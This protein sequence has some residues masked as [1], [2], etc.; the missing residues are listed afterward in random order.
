MSPHDFS[1]RAFL[2]NSAS[3]LAAAGTPFY[4]TPGGKTVLVEAEAFDSYGGWS[5]DSQFMDVMGSPYLMAHGLGEPVAD[6]VTTVHIP[7]PGTYRVY[8]RTVNWAAK[9]DV[10]GAP[11][12]FQVAVNGQ[13]LDHVFGK[14]GAAW[15]WRE[16]GRVRL[17]A[18]PA[19]LRLVDLTGFN[20]RCDALVLTSDPGFVPP[21]S[22]DELERFRQEA[23]G[24]PETPELMDGYDLVVVGG[25]MAGSSA[26][27]TAARLGL[28]VALIQDRPVQ[29]GNNS[30][31]IRV[32]MR[33]GVHWPP[34]RALGG[35]VYEL[36]PEDFAPDVHKRALTEAEPHLDLFLDTRMVR[37]ETEGK[38]IIAIVTQNVRTARQ[39][40]FVGRCFADCT[41]DGN[42]GF[43]AGADYR[44]GRES[45]SQTGETGAPVA[46]D[47]QVMGATLK[48][49]S[50]ETRS[51][52]GF[53]DTPWA[54]QFNEESHQPA[55]RG[56][57]NWEAGFYW[58]Q[59]DE[60][61]KIRDHL[62]RAIFG[63]WSY[64]KNR[65]PD[66]AKYANYRLKWAAHILGKRESRRLLGDVILQE[67]DIVARREF[68]DA[69]VTTTWSIDV[70]YP[71]PANA[72]H[73]SKTEAF[74][75]ESRFFHDIDPYPVPYRCLYSRNIE[76]LF[77]AGRCLSVSHEALGTIR[78]MN[79]LGM[80]GVV[81][82]RAAAVAC[83]H[84][85]TNRR[86]C[87][88][89]WLSQVIIEPNRALRGTDYC[90]TPSFVIWRSSPVRLA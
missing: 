4:T 77:M 53:P 42:L 18:G 51:P 26:A 49:E 66:K 7:E 29:G 76:N 37:A 78:V 32:P 64:Q 2:K 89:E 17:P 24:L 50:E 28:S 70:H 9:F 90:T 19:E 30:S 43:A 68:P 41:G 38:R 6:A 72:A 52:S 80:V 47:N 16:G 45:L 54:V 34:Y 1:R 5:R 48:W 36:G 31:E 84:N 39:A 55:L 71:S 22:P 73:F 61:E 75:A 14:E 85:T 82:G 12:R 81:V 40:R 56:S 11:G 44:Y 59:V 15:S 79:T 3:A 27:I 74:R 35:V 20:G 33:G 8:A 46:P 87:E 86:E 58:H 23:L 88:D 25:G 60:A 65:A 62:L 83:A 69:A 10:P 21:D 63:T 57:W 13:S 67:Q